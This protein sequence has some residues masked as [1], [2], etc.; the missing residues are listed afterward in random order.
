M[1]KKMSLRDFRAV[2]TVLE[3][4]DFAHAPGPAE[5]PV[6]DLIDKAVWED[7]QTLPET[8]AVFTSSDHGTQLSLLSEMMC[9]APHIV[10]QTDRL[11]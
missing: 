4:S 11:A 3:A 8:V 7:I 10:A 2:R 6:K 5:R 9:A 1:P